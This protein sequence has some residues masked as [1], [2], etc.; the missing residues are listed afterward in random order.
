MAI[1]DM[2]PIVDPK[3]EVLEAVTTIENTQPD[4][5]DAQASPEERAASVCGSW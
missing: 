4:H 2:K 1:I 5:P 3:T